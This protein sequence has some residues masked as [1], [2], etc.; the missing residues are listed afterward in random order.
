MLS[1]GE[2]TRCSFPEPLTEAT[3]PA[4]A[5]KLTLVPFVVLVVEK[6]DRGHL[7]ELSP[8]PLVTALHAKRRGAG[9]EERR[10]ESGSDL[11]HQRREK[12]AGSVGSRGL[13]GH[14]EPLGRGFSERRMP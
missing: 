5:F 11:S 1:C 4:L 2:P 12:K 13:G 6:I 10:P 14:L 8:S 9:P 7:V 3:S